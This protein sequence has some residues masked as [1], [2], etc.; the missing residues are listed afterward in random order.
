MKPVVLFALFWTASFLCEG[1]VSFI[2]HPAIK[3]VMTQ[4]VVQGKSQEMIEGWR[5]KIIST[6]NRRAWDS[7]KYRFEA[8]FP[9]LEYAQNYEAP[10][11]SL[12]VG[13]FENRFDLEPMLVLIK[14][15]FPQA[16]PFRDLI[17]KRELF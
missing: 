17:M 12:K 14:E 7:A 15:K 2:E 16:I 13:A 1:Q 8:H 5:I 10:H 4:Y 3:K 6:T 11:Y 9:D